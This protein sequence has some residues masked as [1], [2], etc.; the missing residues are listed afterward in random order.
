M[1]D[2][3]SAALRHGRD[4]RFDV[5]RPKR[6]WVKDSALDAIGRETACGFFAYG[7]H[8]SPSDQ[9]HVV[10]LTNRPSF[11]KLDF[12][13]SGGYLPCSLPID[14]LRLKEDNRVI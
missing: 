1:D 3:G 8:C 2:N 13:M 14:G 9:C 10:T 6:A 5:E 7:N 12:I 4:Y 11:P